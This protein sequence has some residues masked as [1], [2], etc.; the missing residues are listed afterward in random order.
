M[1]GK[2]LAKEITFRDMRFD[3]YLYI[4]PPYVERFPITVC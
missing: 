1:N 3:M 4:Y 2:H